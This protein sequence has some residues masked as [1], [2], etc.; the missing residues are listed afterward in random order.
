MPSVTRPASSLLGARDLTVRHTA[1]LK[2]FHLAEKTKLEALLHWGPPGV[3]DLLHH[4]ESLAC[5]TLTINI[6]G[7]WHIHWGER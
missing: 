1:P 5:Q 2:E 4:P 7:K 3:L 6:Y